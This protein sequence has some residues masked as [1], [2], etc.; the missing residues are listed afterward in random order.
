MEKNDFI[1]D[2]D[3]I[4]SY[5]RVGASI[6]DAF[7]AMAYS[8]DKRQAF[9]DLYDVEIKQAQ[10]QCRILCLHNIFTEGGQSASR[11]ILQQQGLQQDEQDDFLG[12]SGDW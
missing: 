11:F 12:G 2:A 7:D 9:A 3:I 1:S 10:A 5:L 4:C 6:D 8:D